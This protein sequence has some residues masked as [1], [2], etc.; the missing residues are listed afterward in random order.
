MTLEIRAATEN[1]VPLIFSFIRK[2]AEYGDISDEVAATEQDVRA[3]LFGPRPVAEALLAFVGSKPG[4]FALYSEGFAA[5][6][7]ARYLHRGLLCGAGAPQ[8]RH[9]PETVNTPAQSGRER[10]CGRLEWSV[11][12]WNE[13]AM[14]F[15][16]DLGAEPLDEWTTFRLAGE[17]LDKLALAS[18]A[19]EAED[20][21][22]SSPRA[23]N[24]HEAAVGAPRRALAA[25]R[26]LARC[27][28][29]LRRASASPM[30]SMRNVVRDSPRNSARPSC[31]SAIPA[32]RTP[33]PP[34]SFSR[35][36]TSTTLPVTTKKARRC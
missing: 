21:R 3:A 7:A 26:G 27:R 25:V 29:R 6:S 16:Q 30:A 1:D 13:R 19:P 22:R 18:R 12:N 2:L 10:G 33:R 11:L 32:R 5:F 24:S 20:L 9:R 23:G 8:S 14:E 31:C 28:R 34:T 15:Y 35:K 36:K 17:A 4:G